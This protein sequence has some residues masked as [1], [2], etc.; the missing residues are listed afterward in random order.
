[1]TG[2]DGHETPFG[3]AVDDAARASADGGGD[4]TDVGLEPRGDAEATLAEVPTEKRNWS[5]DE[6]AE[7]A[8]HFEGDTDEHKLRASADPIARR[9]I[10]NLGRR[11]KAQSGPIPERSS[12][13]GGDYVVY[14][15]TGGPAAPRKE[16]VVG[17]SVVVAGSD[18]TTVLLPGRRRT[19]VRRC[20]HWSGRRPGWRWGRPSASRAQ[21]GRKQRP[22]RFLTRPSE[23]W[24]LRRIPAWCSSRRRRFPRASR[25]RPHRTRAYRSS[26]PHPL[27]LRPSPRPDIVQR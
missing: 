19:W 13:E 27:C 11:S 6:I 14:S 23:P 4:T 12:S 22:H 3:D 16:S 24:R 1:M 2:K 17:P 21:G 5:K 18:S 25:T 26:G 20:L 15:A 8:R 7:L 10:A 9:L